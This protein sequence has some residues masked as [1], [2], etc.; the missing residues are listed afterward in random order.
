MFFYFYIS[1]YHKGETRG[2]YRARGGAGE[3]GFG[4]NADGHGVRGGGYSFRGSQYYDFQSGGGRRGRDY[5]GD[6]QGVGGRGCTSFQRGEHRGHA[7]GG[8]G[9]YTAPQVGTKLDKKE[10][11]SKKVR[12]SLSSREERG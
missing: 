11:S 1:V 6:H 12:D 2:R 3:G 9:C 10:E 4:Y 5:R 8:G 7:R